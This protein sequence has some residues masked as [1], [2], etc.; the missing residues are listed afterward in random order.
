MYRAHLA[1]YG[2]DSKP[3][4]IRAIERSFS[5]KAVGGRTGTRHGRPGIWVERHSA[6]GFR[7][8]VNE[9]I[10]FALATGFAFEIGCTNEPSLKQAQIVHGWFTGRDALKSG[11]RIAWV[12]R[13]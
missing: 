1:V 7:E 5:P 12:A 6:Q 11:S 3:L 9:V 4:T 8:A 2:T 13:A 10:R